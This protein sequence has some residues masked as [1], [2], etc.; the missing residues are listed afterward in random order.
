MGPQ[1]MPQAGWRCLTHPLTRFTLALLAVL[2]LGML[3]PFY[4]DLMQR[5]QSVDHIHF[6]H[7]PISTLVNFPD[8]VVPDQVAIAKTYQTAYAPKP[9]ANQPAGHYPQ[10]LTVSL[11]VG[12]PNATIY[13]SLD[14]SMPTQHSLHYT[15][16]I[17]ITHTTVLRFRNFQASLLPSVTVT[18]TYLIAEPFSLPVLSVATHPAGVW[19]R[20]SGIYTQF[21][22][23]GRMWSKKAS[24]EYL[25]PASKPLSPSLHFPAEISIH[26]N[27]SRYQAKKSF[28]LTYPVKL[29]WANLSPLAAVPLITAGEAGSEKTIVVRSGGSHNNDITRLHGLLFD[30]L[31]ASVAGWVS[32]NQP[33]M[34]MIN[35]S[36]WG[37]YNIYEHI[38]ETYL[39][40]HVGP[41]HYDLMTVN[42]CSQRLTQQGQPACYKAIAGRATAWHQVQ[43]LL[44]TLD[45]SQ[46]A[47]IATLA[48]QV[49]LD[50]L[51]DYVLLNSYSANLDWPHNNVYM[52]RAASN[53]NM[54]L[55]SR[56]RWIAWD[57]DA[58]FIRSD[59]DLFAQVLQGDRQPYRNG[60]NRNTLLTRTL[61]ANP[62][63]RQRFIMRL[64]DL[65][66]TVLQ[67][68]RVE[69]VLDELIDTV[70]ADLPQD[71]Q[72]WPVPAVARDVPRMTEKRYWRQVES[73]RK[74]VRDR[75]QTLRQQM[76]QHFQLEPPITLEAIAEPA[77][78]GQIS[79]NSM[80]AEALPWQGQYFPNL[81]LTVRA[82]PAPGF[83]FVRWS[84]PNLGT[85]PIIHLMPREDI[86]LQA[87]YAP[88]ANEA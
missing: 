66:N 71:W 84:S 16:P 22:K 4:G 9:E 56:W 78:A 81:P 28:Q 13:Y 64:C 29:G 47:D 3:H 73:M 31:Y 74:F 27:S 67:P 55:D 43:T 40:R 17:A 69:A 86:R 23:R 87:I 63:Y 20:H 61:L 8:Q 77:G 1:G 62:T 19:D 41:G 57:N 82:T 46:D 38:D 48:S 50:N 21:N 85:S 54:A 45:P 11:S 49:D 25:P 24:V 6:E 52:F 30:R 14:G 68:D 12:H 35:G 72:R 60:S 26:G 37:I 83:R 79:V 88:I 15:Q 65:L 39:Q 2:A 5:L 36:S 42:P 34:L 32:P 10:P 7:N 80:P 51:T 18:Q 76:Q 33:V 70:R 53:A 59:A 58:S 44:Q 75:P